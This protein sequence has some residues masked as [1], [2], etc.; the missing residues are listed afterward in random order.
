M[1]VVYDGVGKDTFDASLKSCGVGGFLVAFGNASGKVS[2][3]SG[4]IG[5]R[6]VRENRDGGVALGPSGILQRRVKT[7]NRPPTG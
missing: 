1:H 4:F 5:R 7:S 3:A 2:G 6:R